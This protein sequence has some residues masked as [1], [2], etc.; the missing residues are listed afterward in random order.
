MKRIRHTGIY[1]KDIEIMRNFYCKYFD[2][3]VEINNIEEGEY[4]ETVLGVRKIKILVN[5]LTT[6]D[7]CMLELIKNFSRESEFI[8]VKTLVNVGTY[9]IAF[10][11]C[12]L[13]NLYRRMMLENI[14]FISKPEISSDGKAKVCFCYDPEG[15]F[16]ELVEEL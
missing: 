10:T 6:E 9:H 4:I 1:V 12:D 13:D 5:K 11:V 15:N 2:M 3:K 14:K 16:V 8:D 7:G